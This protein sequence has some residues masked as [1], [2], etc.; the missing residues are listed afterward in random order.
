MAGSANEHGSGVWLSM[1]AIAER[2]KMSAKEVRSCLGSMIERGLIGYGD[3][4]EI[5]AQTRRDRRPIVY[6]ILVPASWYSPTALAAVNEARRSKGQP[7]L[8]SQTCGNAPCAERTAAEQ[9]PRCGHRPD[10]APAPLKTRRADHGLPRPKKDAEKSIGVVYY[11]RR[12]DGAIK[13]G[14]SADLETRIRDLSRGHGHLVLL[15][16]EPGGWDLEQQRHR[17]FA[18]SRIGLREWFRPHDVLLRHIEG[19]VAA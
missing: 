4:S 13:V 17:D 10:I 8:T 15:A 6:D 18:G 1:S 16:T 5:P 12:L 3:Q 11:I 7:P 9:S 2:A 19:L 14:H